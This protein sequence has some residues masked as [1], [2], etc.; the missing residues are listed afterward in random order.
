MDTKIYHLNKKYTIVWEMK[1][2]EYLE[3]VKLEKQIRKILVIGSGAVGK[4]S[5][6][7]VLKTNKP[8]KE[9]DEC[10]LEYNRTL[11]LEIEEIKTED[12]KGTFQLLDLAGQLDLPIHA[13]RDIPRFAFGAVDLILFVFAN[14]N[15]QSLLDIQEWVEIVNNYYQSTNLDPPIG[16]LINNK[17]DLECSFDESLIE[18]IKPQMA[19][20]FCL[21]CF[22]GEGI[23]NLKEW[24]DEFFLECNKKF[25]VDN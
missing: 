15:A 23:A 2:L 1:E 17:T 18:L 21:S 22:D 8:L 9:F 4:T 5:L 14:D 6:I 7:K 24:L 13:S 11:F 19:G 3:Y 16:I 10:H 20:Y 25:R 12:R